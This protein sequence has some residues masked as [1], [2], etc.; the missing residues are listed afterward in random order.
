MAV[1]KINE[2]SS[3]GASADYNNDVFLDEDNDDMF[4]P[5][6]DDDDHVLES[7]E[8]KVQH[9]EA[10]VKP[11]PEFGSIFGKEAAASAM[12]QHTSPVMR[13]SSA[14]HP[15][16]T[17]VAMQEVMKSRI[18]RDSLGSSSSQVE[19]NK[20]VE[21][22]RPTIETVMESRL[23]ANSPNAIPPSTGSV[24]SSGVLREKDAN[25][26]QP[27]ATTEEM[28]KK[29]T[30]TEVPRRQ[31]ERASQ[32]T[33]TDAQVQSKTAPHI[34]AS[35]GSVMSSSGVLRPKDPNVL[36]TA[37]TT[38]DMR[39]KPTATEASR[40][41]QQSAL[42]PSCTD[43]HQRSDNQQPQPAEH[44]LDI[45]GDPFFSGAILYC[46]SYVCNIYVE[47]RISCMMLSCN[48]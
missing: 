2:D 22:R 40:P 9:E 30:T 32:T 35:S 38:Q 26:F 16:G 6:D 42:Q 36:E 28:R 21:R 14:I 8:D 44:I 3:S 1:K 27:T 18:P 12:E 19:S 46:V 11:L 33:S 4:P 37:S 5:D 10:S 7:S 48:K 29:P 45:E 17:N 15:P 41:E 24:M 43:V 20:S 25:I 39:K 31:E 23:N 47:I 13:I 34:S